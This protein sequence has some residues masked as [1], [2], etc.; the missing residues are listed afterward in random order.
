VAAQKR[1]LP[2]PLY[3][4]AKKRRTKDL[5]P[6]DVAWADYMI[7]GTDTLR[8]KLGRGKNS[9]GITDPDSLD[10]L[11]TQLSMSRMI[12]LQQK[13]IPGNFD[14]GHM[15]KIHEFLFQDTYEWAGQQRLVNLVKNG[16]AY[17]PRTKIE[18][19]WAQQEGFL[20]DDGMLR[21]ITDPDEFADKFAEH[22]GALNVAHSFREGNTRSQ[23]MY[24][25]QLADEAG[26]DLDVTMLDPNHPES[27]RDE[28]IE[29][30]FHHQSHNFDHAP[31]ARV[32]TKALTHREPELQR[33]LHPGKDRGS[34]PHR[35]SRDA[36]ES[37]WAEPSREELTSVDPN[38]AGADIAARYLKYPE[39][40]PDSA[41]PTT[42][43]Q[44]GPER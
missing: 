2:A 35:L 33:A 28:F 42:T 37:I 21:G 15:K 1:R 27:I 39:L 18:T 3:A 43:D 6:A 11:E 41:E 44:Q 19:M 8:N 16:H 25:K 9:Y 22:W 31:L 13:P 12:E 38:P 26:W 20:A 30:R 17:A 24:F 23:T 5:S 29:A 10:E 4:I 40:A 34:V 14:Y 7:P 36:D 32:L